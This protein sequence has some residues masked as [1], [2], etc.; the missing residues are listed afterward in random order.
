MPQYFS[1]RTF[2]F[3]VWTKFQ[4]TAKLWINHSLW[5]VNYEQSLCIFRVLFLFLFLFPSSRLVWICL[6]RFGDVL[7]YTTIDETCHVLSSKWWDFQYL[8]IFSFPFCAS[9]PKIQNRNESV[10]MIN[11]FNS[12]MTKGK[13]WLKI[14]IIVL[15]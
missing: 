8:L 6:K 5:I 1:E 12:K 7:L 10:Q 2:S 13:S 4:I 15:S 11:D 3:V 14:I 9:N